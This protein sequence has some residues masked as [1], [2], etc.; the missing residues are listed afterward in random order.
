MQVIDL[1]DERPI[2][3]GANQRG[4]RVG[5]WIDVNCT[6]PKSKP[7]ATLKW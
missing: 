7:P 2:I 4:Y 3:S 5:E 1:P 6:S